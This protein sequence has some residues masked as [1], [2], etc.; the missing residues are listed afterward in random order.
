MIGDRR[1]IS[2]T[3]TASLPGSPA[4]AEMDRRAPRVNSRVGHGS[5]PLWIQPSSEASICAGAQ[6]MTIAKSHGYVARSQSREDLRPNQPHH[7]ARLTTATASKGKGP[8]R[9]HRTS[10]EM[11]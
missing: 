11:L 5:K 9:Q 2:R 3:N 8:V 4:Y 10:S 1:W 7:A 6:A